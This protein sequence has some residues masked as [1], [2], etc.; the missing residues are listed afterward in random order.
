MPVLIDTMNKGGVIVTE[1]KYAPQE[2]YIKEKIRRF[3]L[4]ANRNTEPDL[5][6]YLEKQ[7]NLQQYLRDLIRADMKSNYTEI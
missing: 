2:K 6:E 4:N 5:V 3:V 7:E 1:K